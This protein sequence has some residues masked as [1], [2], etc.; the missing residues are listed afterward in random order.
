MGHLSFRIPGEVPGQQGVV[1]AVAF[2]RIGCALRDPV[3]SGL[4]RL[5]L[6]HGCSP[7]GVE[8]QR[9]I[10]I[11]AGSGAKE[12]NLGN[13]FTVCRPGRCALGIVFVQIPRLL[14]LGS[15]QISG[16]G[17]ARQVRQSRL[18]WIERR[19]PTI[20]GGGGLSSAKSTP[21]FFVEPYSL[22]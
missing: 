1:A 21:Q 6:P 7:A 2:C 4:L 22:N 11:Q 16:V 9:R 10:D 5:G 19:V 17:Y 20:S 15:T 13:S 8:R 12:N 3:G 18:S 14:F